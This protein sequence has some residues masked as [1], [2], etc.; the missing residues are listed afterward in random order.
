MTWFGRWCGESSNAPVEAMR[1]IRSGLFIQDGFTWGDSK[2]VVKRA[3]W[4]PAP[5]DSLIA[6]EVW[7]RLRD[8][9]I[10]RR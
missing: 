1:D 10:F 2:L 7:E 8:E 6:D 9:Y 5:N 4:P 3:G